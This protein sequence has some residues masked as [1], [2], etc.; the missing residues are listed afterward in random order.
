VARTLS[1]LPGYV[2]TMSDS[3]LWLHLYARS[4]VTATL[5]DAGEVTVRQRTEYPWDGEVTLEVQPQAP[6]TFS[7]FVRVPAWAQGATAQINGRPVEQPVAP[8]T[9]LEL[10]RQ[11]APGDVVRLTLPMPVR[12]L[13]AHPRVANDRGRA[14]VLRGPLVYCV[15]QADHPGTDVW[16]LALPAQPDWQAAHEPDLL[17]GVTVLRVQALAQ[18]DVE[19]P[20]YRPFDPTPPRY[21]PVSLTAIPYYAWANREPGPMQVWL[22]MLTD[23]R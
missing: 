10:R 6:C 16:D 1:S 11:W 23:Q 9:Y 13:A 22:P 14:A 21:T 20:L 3:G 7:L 15:E 8:G 4:T 19:G 5:G 2:A 12:L 18:L 17:D